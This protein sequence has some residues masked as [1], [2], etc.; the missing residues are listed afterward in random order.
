HAFAHPLLLPVCPT[1]RSSDLAWFHPIRLKF[2]KRPWLN[3]RNHRKLVVIDDRI[4]FTGGINI[5]DEQ[6]ETL[7]NTAYRDL[8]VRVEGR[9]R[10][11]EHTSELQSREN[12]VCRLL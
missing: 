4:G 9:V 10:S 1:R 2:W 12:L 5:T 11:E 6:D 7:C 3:L 8:H